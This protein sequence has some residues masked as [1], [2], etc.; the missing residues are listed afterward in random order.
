MYARGT[1]GASDVIARMSKPPYE[2]VQAADDKPCLCD[3]DALF[4]ESCHDFGKESLVCCFK[5]T[6]VLGALLIVVMLV[7]HFQF[8]AI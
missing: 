4:Q 7:L 6:C 2:R 1:N 3:C 5:T 8:H